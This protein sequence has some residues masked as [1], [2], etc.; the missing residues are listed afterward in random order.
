MVNY[1]QKVLLNI[2]LK[3]M[4]ISML[5]QNCCNCKAVLNTWCINKQTPHPTNIK[6][7]VNCKQIRAKNMSTFMYPLAYL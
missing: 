3:R 1:L 4:K 5:T 2:F 7:T 6:N